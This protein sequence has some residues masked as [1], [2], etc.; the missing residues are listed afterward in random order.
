VPAHETHDIVALHD[1]KDASA[2]VHATINRSRIVLTLAEREDLHAEGMAIMVKLARDYQPHI[3]GH[4]HEGRFSGYAAMYLP[5]KLGD[6]WHRNHPEHQLRTQDDGKR[7]WEYSERAVSL[8]A[9]AG[10]DPDRQLLLAAKRQPTD[11]RGRLL[12]AL[13]RRWARRRLHYADVA[14]LL[15]ENAT[16]ADVAERLGCT[17]SQVQEAIDEIRPVARQLESEHDE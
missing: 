16:P 2:F 13:D 12:L 8:D 7:R 1:V 4:D 11:L 9:L 3:A 6:V 17:P 5:R 14:E 10:V 15:W